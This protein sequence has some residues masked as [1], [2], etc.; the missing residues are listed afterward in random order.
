MNIDDKKSISSLPTFSIGVLSGI[1]I[2]NSGIL[3]IASGIAIGIFITQYTDI[4]Y[5]S[6]LNLFNNGKK[7]LN[8]IHN[9]NTT[10]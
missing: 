4:T 3:S 10:S 8:Y 6:V 2:S 7:L 1:A 5:N 9:K